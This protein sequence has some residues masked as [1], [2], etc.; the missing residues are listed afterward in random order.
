MTRRVAVAV[1][2]PPTDPN[3]PA[4]G[5]K[6]RK[7]ELERRILIW[8]KAVDTQ[9][10]FNEMSHKSRQLGLSVLVAALGAVAVVISKDITTQNMSAVDLSRLIL[11][12]SLAVT[13]SVG[14]LD[15]FVY[16]RLLV[17]AVRFGWNL[18][19]H[20]FLSDIFGDAHHG[21][22]TQISIDG[23]NLI[24][25]SAT[26]TNERKGAHFFRTSFSRILAFYVFLAGAQSLLLYNPSLGRAPASPGPSRAEQIRAAIE[27]SEAAQSQ[28]FELLRQDTLKQ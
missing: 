12:M 4:G 24:P 8:S 26:Q 3:P 17:G 21:M 15:L 20:G 7:S 23:G 9:M 18:E 16:Q 10:H 6:P 1:N 13:V 28:L 25:T 11:I 5:P 14:V 22:T 19:K 27:K 2:N